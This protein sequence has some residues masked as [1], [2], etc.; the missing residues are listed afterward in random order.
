VKT[1][2]TTNFE[3]DYGP[4]LGRHSLRVTVING[5]F[6]YVVGPAGSP[7][8]KGLARSTAPNV[9][10]VVLPEAGHGVWVDQPELFERALRRA[11]RG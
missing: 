6:D 4:D 2:E 1:R 8:W 7:L 11:L 9:E 5:Y 10:V 3:Y